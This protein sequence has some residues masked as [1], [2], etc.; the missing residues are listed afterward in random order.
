MKTKK[1][2]LETNE[3]LAADKIENLEALIPTLNKLQNAFAKL[4]LGA[5]DE[6]IA[7]LML[8][9]PNQ[10]KLMFENAILAD[11]ASSGRKNKNYLDSLL[12]LN[13]STIEEF[14]QERNEI[15]KGLYYDWLLFSFDG[16]SYYLSGETKA[17]IYEAEK[18]FLTPE[19]QTLFET[20]ESIIQ[21]I[22]KFNNAFEVLQDHPILT[23]N[24]HVAQANNYKHS[25]NLLIDKLLSNHGLEL[26][27]KELYHLIKERRPATLSEN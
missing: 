20:A 4:D 21:A 1:F 13:A 25:V 26:N 14:E 8:T 11:A 6:H 3:R 19:Q 5:F 16:A 18:I 27:K 12:K 22:V 15:L 2:L 24:P 7:S 9:D 23:P 17:A 10:I